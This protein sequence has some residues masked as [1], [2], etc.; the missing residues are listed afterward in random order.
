MNLLLSTYFKFVL[1]MSLSLSLLIFVC[2]QAQLKSTLVC[3]EETC[4]RV[5]ITFDP[6]MSLSVPVPVPKNR[7]VKIIMF[8]CDASIVPMRIRVGVPKNG[9]ISDLKSE[10]SKVSIY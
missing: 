9:K 8:W 1:L 7:M 3:P 2:P 10:L 5:S 6:Y 4:K